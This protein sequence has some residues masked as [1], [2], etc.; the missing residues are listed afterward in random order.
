ME[1]QTKDFV[2]QELEGAIVYI[3]K[4]YV[5]YVV[6]KSCEIENKNKINIDEVNS[7]LDNYLEQHPKS[8]SV[9]NNLKKLL[10]NGK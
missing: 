6:E 9:I 1:Q 8:K 5:E 2:K 7:I 3:D 4:D 10:N